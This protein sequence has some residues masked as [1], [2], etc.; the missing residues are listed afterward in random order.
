[1]ATV[2]PLHLA[3]GQPGLGTQVQGHLAASWRVTQVAVAFSP[4]ESLLQ[5]AFGMLE[6]N[7]HRR[8]QP[9]ELPSALLLLQVRDEWVFWRGDNILWLPVEYRPRCWAVNN[10]FLA[11]GHESGR[12]T[13]IEFDPDHI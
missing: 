9:F 12:V 3:T 7:H 10:N 4:D 1:M 11:L 13:F 2:L 6:Q 5:T 8:S